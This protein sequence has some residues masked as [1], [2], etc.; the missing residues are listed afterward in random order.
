MAVKQLILLVIKKSFNLTRYNLARYN[1]VKRI[2]L[3]LSSGS[4]FSFDKSLQFGKHQHS[5]NLKIQLMQRE[6]CFIMDLTSSLYCDILKWLSADFPSSL[7]FF[8]KPVLPLYIRN[9]TFMLGFP[10]L[11]KVM[12]TKQKQWTSQTLI[13]KNKQQTLWCFG[14]ISSI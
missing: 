2:P 12:N 11:E 14:F 7:P 1:C 10:P 13:E 6:I 8:T 3:L 5:N 9:P 4:S